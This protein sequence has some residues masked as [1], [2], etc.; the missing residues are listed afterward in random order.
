MSNNHKIA[1]FV[2]LALTIAV[3]WWA[4]AFVRPAQAP[5]PDPIPVA[6]PTFPESIFANLKSGEYRLEVTDFGAIIV[7]KPSEAIWTGLERTAS[8]AM[9][10][11]IT[12]YDSE[13][14]L[15]IVWGAYE[16][17]GRE[18]LLQFFPKGF[19]ES[20][21]PWEGG[22]YDSCRDLYFDYGGRVL[23]LTRDRTEPNLRM[24]NYEPVGNG[25]LRLLEPNSFD[26]E[27]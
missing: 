7:V 21:E 1:V 24:P 14:D 12:T 16:F 25:L 2:V 17:E 10:T 8:R 20:L 26:I 4:S 27:G 19:D 18:C 22:F 9:N 15:F 11:T 5:E 3:V 13:L 23:D 6:Q